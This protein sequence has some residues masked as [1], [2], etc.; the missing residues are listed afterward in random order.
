VETVAAVLAFEA[1]LAALTDPQ[2]NVF[3]G[4]SGRNRSSRATLR[5]GVWRNAPSGGAG[6]RDRENEY[7]GSE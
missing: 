5:S 4:D 6:N 2:A 7:R 1:P 3:A